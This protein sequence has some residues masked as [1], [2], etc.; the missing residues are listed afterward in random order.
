MMP[1]E[2][3]IMQKVGPEFADTLFRQEFKTGVDIVMMNK[4]I[5]I[6]ARAH[7]WS[8]INLL[9]QPESLEHN[10]FNPPSLGRLEISRQRVAKLVGGSF[11]SFGLVL[12]QF[13]GNAFETLF[14][15]AWRQG[16]SIDE[17]VGGRANLAQSDL[18]VFPP[19]TAWFGGLG[20]SDL[21]VSP[22]DVGG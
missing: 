7:G 21:P 3:I 13:L 12:D 19:A 20:T 10:C 11:I 15:M 16:Q 14:A 8:L 17:L 18:R 1:R 6:P 22:I 9:T 4:D 5:N 2:I